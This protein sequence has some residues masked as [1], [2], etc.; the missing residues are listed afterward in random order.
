MASGSTISKVNLI[1]LESIS[2]GLLKNGGPNKMI[3]QAWISET[4]LVD[5]AKKLDCANC[6]RYIQSLCQNFKRPPATLRQHG[7]SALPR[8][9]PVRQIDDSKK[10][11]VK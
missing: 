3:Q 4:L 8:W 10:D 1:E 5:W 11:D 9:V 2:D 7:R 6:K